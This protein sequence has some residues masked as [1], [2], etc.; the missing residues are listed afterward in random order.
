MNAK[1][2][3]HKTVE[4]HLLEYAEDID[5][6]IVPREDAEQHLG[7]DFEVIPRNRGERGLHVDR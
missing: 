6:S 4:A 5:W 7:F 3:E 1:P 2:G